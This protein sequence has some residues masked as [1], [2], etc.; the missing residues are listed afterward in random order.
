MLEAAA[1][2]VKV[3]GLL[4]YSTCSIEPEENQEQVA[5]FLKAHPH[6]EV[7]PI[8]PALID[9]RVLTPEG[10]MATLPHRDQIDGAFAARLRRVA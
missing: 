10:F 4:V 1:H 2:C 6:F 3:G 8:D 5:N 7:A 9:P